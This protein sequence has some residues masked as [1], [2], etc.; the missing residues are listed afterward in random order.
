MLDSPDRA[1]MSTLNSD[2]LSRYL[3]DDAVVDLVTLLLASRTSDEIAQL[4]RRHG[5]QP[6]IDAARAA[7]NEFR[8]DYDYEVVISLHTNPRYYKVATVLTLRRTL[9][10][11]EQHYVRFGRT[12][13]AIRERLADDAMLGV[14]LVPVPSGAWDTDE[15]RSSLEASVVVDRHKPA[16]AAGPSQSASADAVHLPI[17]FPE[18]LEEKVHHV[19]VTAGYLVPR[20]ATYF[21][22]K[23]ANV[24]CQGETTISF[25]IDDPDVEDLDAWV[26]LP[27]DVGL[28]PTQD[29]GVV[30]LSPKTSGT[31]QS[32]KVA[33]SDQVLLWP[34]TTVVFVW[35]RP[36]AVPPSS[37]ESI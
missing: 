10:H 24:Y 19:Q 27:G 2:A 23:L 1:K 20:D 28:D 3:S 32:I 4:A 31:S 29:G 36:E 33:T 7:K 26:S 34:G 37:S 8:R 6:I 35:R 9:R 11:E 18:N 30:S 13:N 12:A 21:P 14:E 25:R 16:I 5:W 22:V 15:V 17:T